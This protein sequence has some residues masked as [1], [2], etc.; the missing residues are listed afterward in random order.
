MNGGKLFSKLITVPGGG[1]GR[2]TGTGL[3]KYHRKRKWRRK[4][5]EE[6][7]RGFSSI[8]PADSGLDCAAGKRRHKRNRGSP[9]NPGGGAVTLEQG[10]TGAL[11]YLLRCFIRTPLTAAGPFVLL[12]LA[13][14]HAC[15]ETKR[16]MG[17]GGGLWLWTAGF[18]WRNQMPGHLV[19]PFITPQYRGQRGWNASRGKR[20]EYLL[21]R[22]LN[23]QLEPKKK[24]DFPELIFF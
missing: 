17:R 3:R 4:A 20:G 18:M 9:L 6:G 10:N 13:I 16:G 2:R 12:I 22:H 8:W 19:Q 23:K 7:W 5:E 11:I 15:R 24:R 21:K 1:G 14:K